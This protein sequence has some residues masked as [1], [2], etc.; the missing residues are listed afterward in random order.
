MTQD[1]IN[2]FIE[3]LLAEAKLDNLPEDYKQEYIKKMRQQ[4][5]KRIGVLA[6][7]EMDQSALEEFSQLVKSKPSAAE[8]NKFF[9]DKIPGFQEKVKAGLSDFALEFVQA[10]KKSQAEK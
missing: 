1:P 9:L 5:E 8:V 2:G 6:M 7:M 10:T 4:I 3:K